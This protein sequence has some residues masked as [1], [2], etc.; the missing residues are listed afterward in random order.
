[1][2]LNSVSQNQLFYCKFIVGSS[3]KPKFDNIIEY[4]NRFMNQIILHNKS[5]QERTF[6]FYCEEINKLDPRIN[7]I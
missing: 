4:I 3:E 6:F 5:S 7:H 2:N 1:M